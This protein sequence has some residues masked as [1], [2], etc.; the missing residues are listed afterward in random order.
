MAHPVQYSLTIASSR[1]NV[2]C[3]NKGRARKKKDADEADVTLIK[4]S[5]A[6]IIRINQLRMSSLTILWLK[7]T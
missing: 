7:F 5:I 4:E 2:H 1:H 6:S 3:R